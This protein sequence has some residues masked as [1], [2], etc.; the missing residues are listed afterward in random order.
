MSRGSELRKIF[1]TEITEH[2]EKTLKPTRC[3]GEVW[4]SL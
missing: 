2:T 1:T 3:I 4:G